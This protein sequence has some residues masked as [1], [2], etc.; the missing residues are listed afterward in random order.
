[1]PRV[2]SIQSSWKSCILK[3]SLMIDRSKVILPRPTAEAIFAHALESNPDERCGLIGGTAEGLARNIYPLRNVA[4]RPAV[5]Y[6]AAPEELFGAQREMRLR[7]EELIAIY[8]SHPRSA[9]PQPS[10]TDVRQA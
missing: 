8:H 5:A 7:N 4:T 9:E 3:W 6:E 1:M 2:K 10:E